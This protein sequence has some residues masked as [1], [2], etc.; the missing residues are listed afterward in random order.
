MNFEQWLQAKGFEPATLSDSQKT[1]LQAAFQAENVPAPAP[2]P[3][4][5]PA[6]ARG[7]TVDDIVQAQ[8]RENE[9]QER[10]TA[11]MA[12]HLTAHSD[13]TDELEAMARS[14]IESGMSVT[15]FELALLRLM[16]PSSSLAAPRHRERGPESPQVIEAAL[17]MGAGLETL[18]SE[19]DERT[20]EA[21][22]RRWRRGLSLGEMLLECARANGYRGHSLRSDLHAVLRTAFAP[23][24]AAGSTSPSYHSLASTVLSNTAN[25]HLKVGFDAVDSAWRMITATR[26]VMDFKTI[27]SYSLTGDLTYDVLPPGGEL[28]HGTLGAEGYTN[29]ADTYGKM[30]GIDRRDLI[31]DDLGALSGAGRRLGRGAAIK[32]NKVFWGVFLNNSSFFTAGRNNAFTG[33]GTALSITS[34]GAADEKFRVQTDPDGNPLGL[35]PAILLAPTALRIT[36]INLVNSELAAPDSTGTANTT[37]GT[38][39]PTRNPFQ[40]A[41]VVVSSPYMQDT[42]LTG[43]SAAAWYLLASPNDLPVIETCFLNGQES[44]TVETADAD[45]GTLGIALRGYHDFGVSLQEYRAGVRYAGA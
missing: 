10:I 14:A 27:T 12:D 31:N 30:F 38:M 24:Q 4:P 21:A 29:R 7:R 15:D 16:R 35:M 43:Y 25:K 8:R 45:F 13:L 19:F 5:V 11:L 41:Y 23:V 36:A 34:L 2:T 20:L 17:C 39:F 42:T 44:P 22:R 6:P 33:G 9:R 18:E 3:A 26:S 37:V 32:L 28:K 1:A 40:S